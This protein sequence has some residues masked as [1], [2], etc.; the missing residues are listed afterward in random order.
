MTVEVFVFY[1]G[2]YDK[3]KQNLYATSSYRCYLCILMSAITT[4]H[5][6]FLTSSGLP[7]LDWNP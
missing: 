1:L 7:Q 3:E 4:L 2:I 6:N 5:D